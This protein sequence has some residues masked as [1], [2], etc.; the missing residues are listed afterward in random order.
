MVVMVEEW[1]R[2]FER[3]TGVEI[4]ELDPDTGEGESFVGHMMLWNIRRLWR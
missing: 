4:E 2:D 1:L 3:K